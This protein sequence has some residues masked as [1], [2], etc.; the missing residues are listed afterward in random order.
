[1]AKCV[2]LEEGIVSIA[3]QAKW[4][5]QIVEM[6]FVKGA[7]LINIVSIIDIT[8]FFNKHLY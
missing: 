6:H 5:V 4:L 2:L 3:I 7:N 8:L 1:M